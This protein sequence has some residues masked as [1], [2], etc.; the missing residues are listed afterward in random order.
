MTVQPAVTSQS[1]LTHSCWWGIKAVTA[2]TVRIRF[3]SSLRQVHRLALSKSGC[4]SILE[5]G[6][7]RLTKFNLKRAKNKCG[8]HFEWQN[9]RAFRIVDRSVWFIKTPNRASWLF[10]RLGTRCSQASFSCNHVTS[11]DLISQGLSKGVQPYQTTTFDIFYL[12]I[13]LI[14]KFVQDSSWS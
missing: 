11:S 12:W 4:L 1:T 5:R 2:G 8:R 14:L 3:D 10:Q 13:G 7:F 9:K 6:W